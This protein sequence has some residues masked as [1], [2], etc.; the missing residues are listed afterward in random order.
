[1]KSFKGSMRP[2]SKETKQTNLFSLVERGRGG[3]LRENDDDDNG[4]PRVVFIGD[5]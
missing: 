4:L 1:M 3:K 5:K 2:F